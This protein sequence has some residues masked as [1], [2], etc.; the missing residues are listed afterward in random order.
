MTLKNKFDISLALYAFRCVPRCTQIYTKYHHHTPI[1]KENKKE[2]M[3]P[4]EKRTQSYK[5]IASY[6]ELK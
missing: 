1:W 3:G 4:G 5:L 2:K 6:L